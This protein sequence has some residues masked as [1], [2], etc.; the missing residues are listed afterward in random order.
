MRFECEWNEHICALQ[1][2]ASRIFHVDQKVLRLTKCILCVIVCTVSMV[3]RVLLG[4]STSQKCHIVSGPWIQV[5]LSFVGPRYLLL[6]LGIWVFEF[7]RNGLGARL[8]IFDE[9]RL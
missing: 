3:F 8:I 5:M 6:A 1:V 7:Y 4:I 2:A 9:V